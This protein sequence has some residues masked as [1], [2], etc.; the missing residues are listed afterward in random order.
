[1]KLLLSLLFSMGTIFTQTVQVKENIRLSPN[2]ELIG[3]LEPGTKVKILKRQGN[4][5]KV[6]IEGYI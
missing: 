4:W 5:A 2:G 3:Q 1:M 6:S